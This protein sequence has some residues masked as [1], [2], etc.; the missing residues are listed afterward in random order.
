M[1]VDDF[2]D[3]SMSPLTAEIRRD[4]L[5][6]LGIFGVRRAL[7]MLTD[8]GDA[9]TAGD[10]SRELVEASGLADL[11]QA[12]AAQFLPRARLLKAR[13]ALLALRGVAVDLAAEG[14]REAV[15]FGGELD[16]ADAGAIEFAILQAAHLVM[17]GAVTVPH[18]EAAEVERA[19]LG[20]DA[21]TAFGLHDMTPEQRREVAL[22]GLTRWRTRSSDPLANSLVV[23]VA[24]TM[25]RLFEGLYASA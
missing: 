9:P 11:R 5:A 19:L 23:T 16:R 14:S 1:S 15:A 12:I 21:A 6:R 7:A 8:D 3:V 17:S 2:C 24:D 13:S 10:L 22:A 25:A 18:D 20:P 4:L